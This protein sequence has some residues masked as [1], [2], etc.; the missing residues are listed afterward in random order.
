MKRELRSIAADAAKLEHEAE[1]TQ[2]IMNRIE[3]AL[4]DADSALQETVAQTVHVGKLVFAATLERDQSRD[5]LAR[6]GVELA[7]CQNEIA[8]LRLESE[9]ARQYVEHAIA[10]REQSLRTRETAERQII[11]AT[12]S[13]DA[14]R[15]TAQLQQEE[16]AA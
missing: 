6:L 5:E 13:M 14:M 15:Q 4:N 12:T 8:R 3:G 10:G 1:Q 9:S 7:D 11:E 16:L 2:M